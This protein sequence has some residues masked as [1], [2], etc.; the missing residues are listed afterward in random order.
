MPPAYLRGPSRVP[1]TEP[2]LPGCTGKMRYDNR[3]AAA[4]ACKRTGAKTVYHCHYCTG[5]HVTTRGQS[6]WEKAKGKP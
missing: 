5:W 1:Y 2:R 6:A 3:A 4:I